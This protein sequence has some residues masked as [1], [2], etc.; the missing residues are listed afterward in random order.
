MKPVQKY[1]DCR[2]CLTWMKYKIMISFG[3]ICSGILNIEAEFVVY[4]LVF[5]LYS[6]DMQLLYT[7]TSKYNINVSLYN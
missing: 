7:M 5:V 3:I 2:G 4:A 6:V 1:M